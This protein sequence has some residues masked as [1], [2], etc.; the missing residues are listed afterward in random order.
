VT[1]ASA[2]AYLTRMKALLVLAVG[3]VLA[4]CG[5]RASTI[6]VVPSSDRLTWASEL[7]RADSVQDPRLVQRVTHAAN[8]SGA[9]VL[10]VLVLADGGRRVP[11]VT[12][13]SSDPAS[14]MKHHLRG[15]LKQID[16]LE[17]D[18]LG[19]VELVDDHG[20]FA[21]SA[22]RWSNG[23]MVHPRPDLDQCS[24]IV[25]WQPVA[26]PPPPCPAP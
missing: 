17:P 15:F 24:P 9:R 11:V 5:S 18:G 8:E 12:L 4:G 22:G 1:E 13:E 23:G 25:H 20:R 19:F 21:W 2:A 6:V 14:Y 16:Y 26:S 10:D 3:F 7:G